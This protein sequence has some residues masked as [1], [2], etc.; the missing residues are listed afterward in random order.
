MTFNNEQMNHKIARGIRTDMDKIINIPTAPDMVFNILL[1][2]N[3]DLKRWLEHVNSWD[4]FK[5]ACYTR[6]LH[7]WTKFTDF[8]IIPLYFKN[9]LNLGHTGA[10]VGYSGGPEGTGAGTAVSFRLSR[11][12]CLNVYLIVQPFIEKGL[13]PIETIQDILDTE[14]RRKYPDTKKRN[15]KYFQYYAKWFVAGALEALKAELAEKQELV[16]KEREIDLLSQQFKVS[17]KSIKHWLTVKIIDVM[18]KPN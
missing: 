18:V 16:T 12:N 10:E 14:K 5:Q 7:G 15:G 17:T 8:N 9:G 13:I 11:M 3:L 2:S 4:E 1:Q 6:Q